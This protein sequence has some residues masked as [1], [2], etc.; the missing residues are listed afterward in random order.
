VTVDK[1]SDHVTVVT[2][3]RPGARNAINAA[4]TKQLEAVVRDLEADPHVW[5][6]VLTGAGGVAFSAGADL[7]EVSEG[8]LQEIVGGPNG[9]AGFVH[10]PRSKPWIAAVEGVALAG[11][12]EIALACD[13]IVASESAAFGLPEVARGL[14][15]SAGGIYRLPR[16][17]PKA[18]AV[19]CILTARPIGAERAFEL[20]MVNRVTPKGQAL[21]EA[22]N[23]ALDVA[24]NAPVA[25]RESL[26]IARQAADLNDNTLRRLSEEAQRRVMTTED[27]AEGPRAFV[28]KRRPRWKGR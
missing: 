20:G 15:A 6:V 5:A 25:V 22:I 12:C 14:I 2:L 17:I 24:S 8:K 9:L 28:E 11:G 18:I 27:F 3:N 26:A 19:E 23:L 21:S 1:R 10:A 7:K 16:A 13:L 4:L